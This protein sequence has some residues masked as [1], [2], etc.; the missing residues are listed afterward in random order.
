MAFF[1][2]FFPFFFFKTDLAMSKD[3]MK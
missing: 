2:P 1:V 3:K